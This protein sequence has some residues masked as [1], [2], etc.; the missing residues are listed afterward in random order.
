M[1]R[2]VPTNPYKARLAMLGLTQASIL[3]KIRALTEMNVNSSE[4]CS[5]L[6]YV[7]M[8]RKHAK[9][10]TAVDELLSCLEAEAEAAE[11]KE[12]K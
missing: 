3:P 5:A 10:R 8:Q 9:I 4:L 1:Q 11:T 7:G 2:P 6:N 12:E